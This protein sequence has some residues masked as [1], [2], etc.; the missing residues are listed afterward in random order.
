MHNTYRKPCPPGSIQ[1]TIKSGDTFYKIARKFN[2]TIAALSK[3]NTT[4][5]PYMVSIGQHICIPG[6]FL[7]YRN[8]L[9]NISFRYPAQWKKAQPTRYTGTDGFFEVSAIFS[10]GTIDD[11]CKSEAFHRLKPYGSNPTTRSFKILGQKAC[12]IFPSIDQ[13]KQKNYHQAALILQ[14]PTPILIDNETYNYFIL[15]ADQ[16]HIVQ[17][18]DTIKFLHT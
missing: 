11:I 9:Y 14:Y 17:L 15:W 12:F 4:I 5:N 7:P 10:T 13:T 18:A 3:S 16:N 1:Y 6:C 8:F 2:T